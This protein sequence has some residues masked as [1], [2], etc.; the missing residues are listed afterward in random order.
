LGKSSWE[1]QVGTND[2]VDLL[3]YLFNAVESPKREAL[4]VQTYLNPNHTNT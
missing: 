1:N 2:K 3:E 4:I